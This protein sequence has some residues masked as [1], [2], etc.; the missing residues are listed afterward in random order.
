LVNFVQRNGAVWRLRP[1]QKVVIKGEWETP[2]ER[3]AAAERILQ[4]LANLAKGPAAAAQRHPWAPP[5][6]SPPPPPPPKRVVNKPRPGAGA[7]P[8]VRWRH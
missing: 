7:R 1:D 4:E 6:P 2:G 3:L 8:G 5:A